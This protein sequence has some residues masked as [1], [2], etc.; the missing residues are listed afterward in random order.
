MTLPNFHCMHFLCNSLRSFILLSIEMHVLDEEEGILSPHQ[1]CPVVFFSFKM[2]QSINIW[3]TEIESRINDGYKSG[4]N[5]RCL[6]FGRND[7]LTGCW[8]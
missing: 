4:I 3:F 6:R 2:S 7:K 1:T 5:K 8:C